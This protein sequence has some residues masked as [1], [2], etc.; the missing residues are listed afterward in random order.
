MA[1]ATMAMV[2][3]ADRVAARQT[4]QTVCREGMAAVVRRGKP[5]R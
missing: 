5:L 2:V 4:A 3:V 1:A